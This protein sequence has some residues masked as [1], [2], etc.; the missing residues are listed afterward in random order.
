[1]AIF[2]KEGN[3]L[4]N[5]DYRKHLDR[6]WEAGNGFEKSVNSQLKQ[7]LSDPPA[8]TADELAQLRIDAQGQEYPLAKPRVDAIERNATYAAKEVGKKADKD[9]INNYLS[10]ISNV[11]ETVATLADLKT[12]Y[13]NGA[14]GLFVAADNGRKYIWTAGVWKDSGVYQSVGIADGGIKP[15][16][17]TASALSGASLIIGGDLPNYDQEN[18][19]FTFGN[20]ENLPLLAW[21]ALNKYSIPQNTIIINDISHKYTATRL[22]FDTINKTFRFIGWFSNYADSEICIM[23]VRDWWGNDTGVPVISANFPVLI[24]GDPNTN[25]DRWLRI[26]PSP[27]M[28]P[29]Y[30]DVT[31]TFDF[32]S[33]KRMT[34]MN[35]YEPALLLVLEDGKSI[36][37]TNNVVIVND[38]A[39]GGKTSITRLVYSSKTNTFVFYPVTSKLKYHEHTVAIIRDNTFDKGR[40][41][42][43]SVIT[44]PSEITLNGSAEYNYEE[45]VDANV[46]AINHRGASDYAPEESIYAYQLSKNLGFKHL[47][48]DIHFTSDNIPVMIHDETINRT[49]VNSDGTKIANSIGVANHT[50]EE[51]NAYDYCLVKD[52]VNNYYKGTKLMTL[53]DLLI[54]GKTRNVQLH[55]ELKVD[56]TNEQIDMIMMLVWKY[57]M[58]RHI[59]W[60]SFNLY[61]FDYLMTLD[62]KAKL[63]FLTGSGAQKNIDLMLPYRTDKNQVI[64]SI[65]DGADKSDLWLYSK[66]DFDI[67]VWAPL[68][69]KNVIKWGRNTAVSGIMSQGSVKQALLL[70]SN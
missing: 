28:K 15:E 68:T 31:H 67:F 20:S 24:N 66:H 23:S 1:M 39:K 11:P 34:L 3:P 70:A 19:T 43:E 37:M 65:S 42:G 36:T 49:A 40:S 56:L 13:P 10:K 46:I 21:G 38:L 45:E 35:S 61:R 51:L 69:D 16:M 29:D 27:M 60:Q 30:N 47:E 7:V 12:K 22:M 41:R 50:L 53:E 63:C 32:N 25:K 26:I 8:G 55:L 44:S 33:S 5:R 2:E 14:N 18:N 58:Q 64:A 9:Y 59:Y 52:R 57:G 48:G 17:L 62:E 4:Q 6:N 54:F